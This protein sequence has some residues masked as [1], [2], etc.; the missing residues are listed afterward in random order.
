MEH[1]L[2]VNEYSIVINGVTYQL[3]IGLKGLMYLQSLPYYSDEDVFIAS[4]ITLHSVSV[5]EARNLYNPV[6]DD[7]L[8]YKPYLSEQ[9]SS[10]FNEDLRD[11]YSRAVGEI[12]ISPA[13]CLQM[14][15]DEINLAYKGYLRRKELEANLYKLAMVEALAGNHSQIQIVEPDEY[16]Q[17]TQHERELTFKKLGE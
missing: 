11:L 12:G 1:Y 14:S 17:G 4:L 6:N 16:I 13:I 8:N 10:F 9:V 2:S 7:Y 3:K 15:P 5:V